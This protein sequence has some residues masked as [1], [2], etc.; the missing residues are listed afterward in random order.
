MADGRKVLDLVADHPATA[1]FVSWKLCR[2]FL[3]EQPPDSVVA[4]ASDTWT[5][6]RHAPDQI[7]QVVRAILLS[8]EFAASRATKVRRPLAI[9]AAF[10]RATGI[11]LVPTEGLWNELANGGQRLFGWPP[12]TGL[13]DENGYFLGANSMRHRWALVLGLSENWWGTGAMPQAAAARW[14]PRQAATGFLASF[15][16]AAPPPAVAAILDGLGWPPDQPID[17]AAPDS[18]KRMARIA[19]L[20]AMTPGFQMA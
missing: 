10:A 11:D 1:R 15:Q 16:G 4:A 18:A 8:P 13:P 6:T 19:A 14:T 20:A 9:A 7:A 17:R 5:K 2:R 12:P 3:G